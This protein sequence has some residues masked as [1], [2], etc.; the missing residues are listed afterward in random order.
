MVTF[1]LALAASIKMAPGPSYVLRCLARLHNQKRRLNVLCC[2]RNVCCEADIS[3]S[4]G[5]LLCFRLVMSRSYI[6]NSGNTC[7]AFR[8]AFRAKSMTFQ[9]DA[10]WSEDI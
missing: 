8:A 9:K 6:Q 1:A 2:L 10:H 4:V 5:A 3:C 7:Y